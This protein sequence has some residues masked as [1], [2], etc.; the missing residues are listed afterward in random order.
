M[1]ALLEGFLRLFIRMRGTKHRESFNAS[2][3]GNRSSYPCARAL[4]G[5]NNFMSRLIDDSMIV[6]L[7]PNSNALSCHGNKRAQAVRVPARLPVRFGA[8][9]ASS[10]VRSPAIFA[11]KLMIPPDSS[12]CKKL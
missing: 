1:G 5:F 8:V 3:E 10:S 6:G 11:R 4:N 7:K 12:R 2:W 9:V